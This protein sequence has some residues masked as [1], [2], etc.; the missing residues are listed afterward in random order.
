M[1]LQSPYQSGASRGDAPLRL[2]PSPSPVSVSSPVSG[3][4]VTAAVHDPSS[5]GLRDAPSTPAR[6]KAAKRR[7]VLCSPA[8]VTPPPLAAPCVERDVALRSSP[9]AYVPQI[10]VASSSGG[11]DDVKPNGPVGQVLLSL[12]R[13]HTPTSPPRDFFG[14]PAPED[15]ELGGLVDAGA[16][17]PPD[18]VAFP[19]PVGMNPQDW[20]DWFTW[21]DPLFAGDLGSVGSLSAIEPAVLLASV[22]GS[23]PPSTPLVDAPAPVP[24]TSVSASVD[25]TRASVEVSGAEGSTEDAPPPDRLPSPPRVPLTEAGPEADE[26]APADSPEGER[27]PPS[28]YVEPLQ[29]EV[30]ILRRQN[31]SYLRELRFWADAISAPGNARPRLPS[32]EE[33]LARQNLIAQGDWPQMTGLETVSLEELAGHFRYVYA[34]RLNDHRPLS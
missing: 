13:P 21:T 2:L 34:D 23:S 29:R 24:E 20:E 17:A 12:D 4:A 18:S 22:A 5:E 33:Q 19:A 11:C 27:R 31:L 3:D 30:Q 7:Q 32:A 14:A 9:E 28:F 6:G 16:A 8:C 26:L 10:L 15:P 1:E 25:Q